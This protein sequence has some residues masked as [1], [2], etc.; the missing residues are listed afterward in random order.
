MKEDK[1]ATDGAIVAKNT[2]KVWT[3]E[4]ARGVAVPMEIQLYARSMGR[5]STSRRIQHDFFGM[6][7]VHSI[8]AWPLELRDIASGLL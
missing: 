6:R 3:I 1:R 8:G 5:G 7:Q 4:H 2:K